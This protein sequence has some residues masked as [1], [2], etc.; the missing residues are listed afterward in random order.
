MR[1]RFSPRCNQ[2]GVVLFMA[3]IVL[4]IMSLVGLAMIR[5]ITSTQVV[6]G[7]L[8]FKEGAVAISDLAVEEAR[9]VI[10]EVDAIDLTNDWTAQS[11][12]SE[13]AGYFAQAPWEFGV[14]GAVAFDMFSDANWHDDNSRRVAA[15]SS[16][17]QENEVRYVIHRLC[18][19]PGPL[20][21]NQ[22]SL[23][24]TT[25]GGS[26]GGTSYNDPALPLTQ[27]PYYRV[28]T[29]VLGPRNTVS[30]TQVILY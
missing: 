15:A 26:K 5:Q 17:T 3:L 30:Y 12:N 24:L 25:V 28:T 1:A 9:R 11:A 23:R 14:T 19:T 2:S 21:T 29:R 10:R 27:Q 20:D 7:N 16:A 4:V 18:R 22:C 6:A 13:A 8:A